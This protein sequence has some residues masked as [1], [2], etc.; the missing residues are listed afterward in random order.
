V[1]I[2]RIATIPNVDDE[3]SCETQGQKKKNRSVY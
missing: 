3:E 1:A 2:A